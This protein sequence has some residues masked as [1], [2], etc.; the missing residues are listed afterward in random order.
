MENYLSKVYN[1]EHPNEHPFRFEVLSLCNVPQQNNDF[2][3]GVYTILFHR[4][5]VSYVEDYTWEETDYFTKKN[6][7]ENFL[8]TLLTRRSLQKRLTDIELL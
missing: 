5:L 7:I 1:Y 2:D 8:L 6:N 3:C 4:A